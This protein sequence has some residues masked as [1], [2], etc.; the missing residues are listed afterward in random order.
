LWKDYREL[1]TL[2]N[3]I[4]TNRP[5]SRR[6]DFKMALPLDLRKKVKYNIKSAC[7]RIDS[8]VSVYPATITGLD[9]SSQKIRGILED[10]NSISYLVP[11]KVER[12][13]KKTGL[14]KN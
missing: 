14:Y 11:D 10:G 1:L 3:F 5:G 6:I 8:I 2:C 7:Y 9:I 4:V 13:I 12:F